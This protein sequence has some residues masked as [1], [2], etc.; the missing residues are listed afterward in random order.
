MVHPFIGLSL[1]RMVLNSFKTLRLLL[2]CLGSEDTD[3]SHLQFDWVCRQPSE[4]K[5]MLC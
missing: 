1:G 4:E 5:R 3:E 2:A